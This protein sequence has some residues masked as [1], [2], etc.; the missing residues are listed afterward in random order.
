MNWRK[1][2]ADI[3]LDINGLN[4]TVISTIREVAS[5]LGMSRRSVRSSGIKRKPWYDAE[6]KRSKKRVSEALKFCRMD[7]FTNFSRNNYYTQKNALGKILKSKKKNY[8][9]SRIEAVSLCR[10][11]SQYWKIIN[12]SRTHGSSM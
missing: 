11:P 1:E 9:L 8:D 6:C 3:I 7:G 12:A 5:E 10:N 4:S 2:V